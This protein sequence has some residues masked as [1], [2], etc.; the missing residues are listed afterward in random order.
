VVIRV[1]KQI[2]QTPPRKRLPEA[3]GTGSSVRCS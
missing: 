1:R 3:A 2:V